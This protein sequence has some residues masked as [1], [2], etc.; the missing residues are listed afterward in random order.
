[1]ALPGKGNKFRYAPFKTHN[2]NK[3]LPMDVGFSTDPAAH[4]CSS[5]GCAA[6]FAEFGA[7]EGGDPLENQ[8]VLLLDRDSGP[9]SS[10]GILT[11]LRSTSVPFISTIFTSWFTER[12]HP[13][14]HFVPIDVRY[15][16]LH[17]TLAYFTGIRSQDAKEEGNVEVTLDGKDAVVKGAVG[18]A[19]W[20]ASQGRTWARTA[21]RGE[22][23]E[24]YLF[25]LLLEWGRVMDEKREELGF[26]YE[27]G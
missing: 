10:P 3:L 9:S 20:I 26:V 21:L 5:R 23:M 2:L 4:T 25:R 16:D 1:M 12:L 11:A 7:S 18:D 6:A 15:T 17:S 19:E 14:V 22:D 27:G 8:Y 24:V 13:W